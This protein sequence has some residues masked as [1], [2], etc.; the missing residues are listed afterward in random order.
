M[1]R[2]NSLY[3]IR[4]AVTS[5]DLEAVR[6]LRIRAFGADADAAD[7]DSEAHLLLIESCDTGRILCSFRLRDFEAWEIS[8]S[9]SGSFYELSA[10]GRYP[11]TMV[12]IGRFCVAPGCADPDVLRLAWS[13][14]TAHVDKRNA[15][16]LFGCSSFQGTEPEAY[17]DTFSIL[18]ARHLAPECWRPRIKAPEVFRY[19]A[20]AESRPDLKRA[21]QA[22][23]PL[24]RSYLMMG[25]WVSDHAVIDRRMNTLHV[26]TG[27]EVAAIPAARK[28]RLR[29]LI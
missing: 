11:G 19:A 10:L 5:H 2:T 8:Q 7:W 1:T 6:A 21:M 25:A 28:R 9:Y 17:M 14:I 12:E 20:S 3:R 13:A 24:L 26:F 22:M 29:A 4:A 16:F 18:R 23:P 15:S 27:L